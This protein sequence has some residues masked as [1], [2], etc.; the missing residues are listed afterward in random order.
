MQAEKKVEEEEEEEGKILQPVHVLSKKRSCE[1]SWPTIEVSI[2]ICESD[3]LLLHRSL[4][5][6]SSCSG[7]FMLLRRESNG[8]SNKSQDNK[9]LTRFLTALAQPR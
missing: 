5:C 9:F 7:F 6:D 1:P 8:R 2:I 3:A 4:P